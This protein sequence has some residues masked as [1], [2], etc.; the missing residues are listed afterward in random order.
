MPAYEQRRKKVHM[1]LKHPDFGCVGK[2]GRVA[3]N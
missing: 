1:I 2:A 3:N